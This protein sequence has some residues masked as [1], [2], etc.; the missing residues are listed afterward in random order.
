ML[1]PL[2]SSLLLQ[3]LTAD[4]LV[5]AGWSSVKRDIIVAHQNVLKGVRNHAVMLCGCVLDGHDGNR[6]RQQGPMMVCVFNPFLKEV[7]LPH[8]GRGFLP[9]YKRDEECRECGLFSP[10]WWPTVG[11]RLYASQVSPMSQLEGNPLEFVT[12]IKW[13]RA[14][15]TCA[16]S[17]LF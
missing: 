13:K 6:Q 7:F 3:C 4:S 12:S 11:Y 15:V 5:A 2:K 9:A 1:I 8:S 16:V 17:D 10:D 14:H